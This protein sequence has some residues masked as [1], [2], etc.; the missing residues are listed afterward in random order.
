MVTGDS[1][2]TQLQKHKI[3]NGVPIV[4]L[5]DG[6]LDRDIASGKFR[7]A[8]N[9]AI[10]ALFSLH[11]MTALRDYF[12]V[13][14]VS[15]VSYNDYFTPTSSTAFNS[16]FTSPGSSEIR[17]DDNK[18]EGYAKLAIGDMRINDAVIIVLV[19]E[20]Q[21]GGTCSM[22]IF[23]KISDIPNGI[24]I[25]YVPLYESDDPQRCFAT[26]LNHEVVGHGFAKLSDE[27]DTERLG[28]ISSS[29]KQEYEEIQKFGFYRNIAFDS[30]VTKSYW[31]N[32]AADSRYKSENLGCYEGGACFTLGVYRPTENSIM[33]ANIG[34]FNVAGRVMIY[35]RCM[36]IAFGNRWKYNEADFIAFDLENKAKASTKRNA[37]AKRSGTFKPLAPPKLIMMPIAK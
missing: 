23:P 31:A 5:G 37:P 33:N 4:I 16:K 17:G 7:E 34:G 6:F 24:S 1:I 10:D 36:N 22:R 28:K 30:D 19:N 3:G 11:P 26:I 32:F 18:A 21:Y 15:A 9:K 29:E 12:D 35:K 20:N 8:T 25:A 2:V 13:Y 27:Y 14:E